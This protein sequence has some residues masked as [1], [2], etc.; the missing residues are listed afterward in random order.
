[1][2]NVTALLIPNTA[3]GNTSDPDCF[4]NAQD[5]MNNPIVVIVD[6]VFQ[7]A[8]EHFR[9]E[10]ESM[11][12]LKLMYEKKIFFTSSVPEGEKKR[13]YGALF[14]GVPA[15]YYKRKRRS[16]ATERHGK[17]KM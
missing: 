12:D 4:M 3:A 15:D 9:I 16:A 10:A 6:K 14:V 5:M 17:S 11:K 8:I 2:E 13:S 7:T 1:M